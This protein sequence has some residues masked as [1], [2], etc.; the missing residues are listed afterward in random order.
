MLECYSDEQWLSMPPGERQAVI[1]READ[2]LMHCCEFISLGLAVRYAGL[3]Y[4]LP[5]C[6]DSYGENV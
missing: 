4:F 2:I 5:L 1:R 3:I 6:H